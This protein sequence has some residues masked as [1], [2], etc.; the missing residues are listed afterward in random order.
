MYKFP[1]YYMVGSSSEDDSTLSGPTLGGVGC[2]CSSLSARSCCSRT[3]SDVFFGS[4]SLI[5]MRMLEIWNSTGITASR[6]KANWNGIDWNL[7]AMPIVRCSVLCPNPF[8]LSFSHPPTNPGGV[9]GYA[10]L[11]FTPPPLQHFWHA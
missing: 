8:S 11:G 3:C 9:G 7:S 10:I 5:W 6:P 4:H 1:I 2:T